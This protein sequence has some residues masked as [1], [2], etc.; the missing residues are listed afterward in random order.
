MAR[1]PKGTQSWLSS[2]ADAL[3]TANPVNLYSVHVSWQ[4]GQV[5]DR[6]IIYD[7]T[8][9]SGTRIATVVFNAAQGNVPVPLPTV[10]K[11]ALNG[12]YYNQNVKAGAE[13]FTDVGFDGL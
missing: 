1:R 13:V 10:G 4:G 12:L 8:S 5:G 3:I 2:G 9:T 7:G 11:E 6:V